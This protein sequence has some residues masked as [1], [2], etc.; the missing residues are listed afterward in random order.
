MV[1]KSFDYRQA[2]AD[3]DEILAWFESSDVAVDEAIDKYKQAEKILAE[4]EEYLADTQAQIKVF[5]N[6]NSSGAASGTPR[7]AKQHKDSD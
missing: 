1:N 7:S 3:L 6:R 5:A 2:R 4:L